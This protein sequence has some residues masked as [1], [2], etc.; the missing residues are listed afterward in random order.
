MKAI[1]YKLGFLVPIKLAP[2]SSK[3]LDAGE[4]SRGR[5]GVG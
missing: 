4:N 2:A 5:W 1:C 3:V